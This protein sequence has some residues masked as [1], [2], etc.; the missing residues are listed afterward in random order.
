MQKTRNLKNR[1]K[2]T[3]R[4]KIKGGEPISKITIIE[5]IDLLFDSYDD[6]KY[7]PYLV[8]FIS[9]IE[10]HYKKK[11]QRENI[12]K[13]LDGEPF[14]KKLF[15]V[16]VEIV[17]VYLKLFITNEEEVAKKYINTVVEILKDILKENIKKKEIFETIINSVKKKYEES[18]DLTIKKLLRILYT[19]LDDIIKKSKIKEIYLNNIDVSLIE[20]INN[21][22][23]EIKC[24]LEHD[25]YIIELLKNDH[26]LELV[27]HFIKS[28]F[29]FS[30]LSTFTSVLFGD[31]RNCNINTI[32][33]TIKNYFT[34]KVPSI[35]PTIIVPELKNYTQQ[36]ENFN[37][38]GYTIKKNPE[39][40]RW[41][42]IFK[43]H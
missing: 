36:S 38:N 29:K 28:D 34:Q 30:D 27:I 8:S 11:E 18:R 31:L 2:G 25:T 23:G 5:I 15:S 10:K 26:I 9:E 20:N 13:L 39:K 43:T 40:K 3:R 7:R 41:F 42:Q 12:K 14:D 37:S 6:K 1:N 33:T 22:K 21:F 19:L 17:L 24:Y 16:L 32:V 35:V 4:R